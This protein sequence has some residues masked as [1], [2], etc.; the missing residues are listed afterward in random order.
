MAVNNA[1]VSIDYTSR[2]FYAIKADLIA[3]IQNKLPQW[4][5]N[6]PADFGVALVEAFAHVG[7]VAN[8]YIDRIA[9]ENYLATATQRQSILNLAAIYGYLPSGYRQ[10]SLTLSFQNTSDADITIPSGTVFSVDVIKNTT[11][12]QSINKEY[13]TLDGDVTV[14]GVGSL[15]IPVT[16]ATGNGTTI[17]Y[18]ADHSF[19]PGDSVTITG[20]STAS[21]D[22]LN[23]SN[24]TVA[25]VTT[26]YF[27]VTNSTV[28]VSSGI[29]SAELAV[30]VPTT[31]TGTAFHGQN[32]S[33]FSENAA[34]VT[35]ANDING[36][37]LG[38]SNALGGQSFTLLHPQVV[39]DSVKVFVRNGDL[40]TEWT[41]VDYLVDYNGTDTVYSLSVDAENFVTIFFGDNVSGAIPAY[42]DSIK[43]T[44]VV[45]GG[46][47]GN[48]DNNQVF[49]V[50]NSPL[51]N[52]Y[53]IDLSHITVSNTTT[54]VGGYDP[55]D[56]DSIRRNAPVSFRSLTRAVSLSDFK[57][58]ALKDSSVGKASAYAD[59][60]TS[61]L[62][63]A[64]PK[65]DNQSST[66]YPGTDNTDPTHVA[67]DPSTWAD[68]HDGLV[69]YMKD[70]TMIGT[71]VSVLPPVYVDA[72]LRVE[73]I[74]DAFHTDA[75]VQ[76]SISSAVIYGF[77]HNFL[78]FD[79]TIRP[80]N[81]EQA[82][83]QSVPGVTA[84]K[85]INLYRNGDSVTRSTLTPA[86]GEFFVFSE[87]NTTIAAG[88]T[89]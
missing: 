38:Y 68:F 46:E 54:G 24:V 49:T 47:E 41:R 19:T 34:D 40:Y 88:T 55:E 7:D 56:N 20:L 85:V 26:G 36:E 13:F 1:P 84:I 79:Q 16:A 59:T 76:A 12:S 53:A 4:A 42:G 69:T 27:T 74:K 73:Y 65:I 89:W 25:T 48:V 3:R 51:L 6:D 8:Y 14:D 32:V 29:G 77:G 31:A 57:S 50:V 66:L 52:G 80:E 28:G 82:L 39:D 2:D 9:N 23:L 17:S 58:L 78:D 30:V 86:S 21:G 22:S 44:Y 35:D 70:K 64:A 18:T 37:L 71:T 43:A 45:G 63:Y 81:I 15:I 67:V 75:E 62:L 87:I 83:I 60:P 5:G 11:T 33:S 61:V 72:V 10:S